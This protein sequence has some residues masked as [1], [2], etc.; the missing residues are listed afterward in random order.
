[1][2][3]RRQINIFSKG[4]ERGFSLVASLIAAGMIGGL[5]LL[6]ADISRQQQSTQK[7]I[8]TN[9]EVNSLF[10]FIVRILQDKMACQLTLGTAL[11]IVDGRNIDFIRNKNAQSVIN[12]AD[13]YGNG[14]LQVESMSLQNVRITK[15][16]PSPGTPY[17]EGSGEVELK[18]VFEKLSRAVTGHNKVSKVVPLSV[19]VVGAN[20]N[21]QTCRNASD[22]ITPIVLNAMLFRAIALFDGK[23]DTARE[24]FCRGLGGIYD[25]SAKSCSFPPPPSSP[26]PIPPSVELPFPVP[27]MAQLSLAPPFTAPPGS[28]LCEHPDFNCVIGASQTVACNLY[29]SNERSAPVRTLETTRACYSH[30]IAHPLK[31]VSSNISCADAKAAC[32]LAA[33]P[34]LATDPPTGLSVTPEE[35]IPPAG[36]FQGYI[37]SDSKCYLSGPNTYVTR[38]R[39]LIRGNNWR[40]DYTC[41]N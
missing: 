31:I 18:I 39:L 21:L 9:F 17:P 20:N 16:P 27:A 12:T 10:N 33:D 37:K 8:E 5:A 2:G 36:G 7:T 11:P 14:L 4:G 28:R 15:P 22:E 26:P 41:T 25:D 23:E 19:K 29:S 35:T 38:C 30:S 13:K 40:C 3:L 34:G 32:R 1:M 24:N 6:L